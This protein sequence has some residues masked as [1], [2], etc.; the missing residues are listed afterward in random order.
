[1]VRLHT[2]TNRQCS[3]PAIEVVYQFWVNVEEDR[4]VHL[5]TRP[6]P[7][8]LKAEA[9]DLVEVVRRLVRH[10]VVRGHTSDSMLAAAMEH[11]APC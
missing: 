5:L 10:N 11:A 8:L 2:N 1:L 3:A 4:H 7:L 9:L 6:Q